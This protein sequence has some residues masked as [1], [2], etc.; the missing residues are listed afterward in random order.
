MGR[1]LPK[2]Q[3]KYYKILTN[4]LPDVWAFGIPMHLW[5]YLPFKLKCSHIYIYIYMYLHVQLYDCRSLETHRFAVA[6][7]LQHIKTSS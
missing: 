1:A 6:N 3:T 7:R 5:I 4:L 2:G